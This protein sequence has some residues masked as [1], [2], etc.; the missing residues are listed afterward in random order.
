MISN[1]L[2][3]AVPSTAKLKV[4]GLTGDPSGA[5]SNTLFQKPLTIMLTGSSA[6]SPLLQ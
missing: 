1:I 5:P 6:K 3:N 4:F 2:A